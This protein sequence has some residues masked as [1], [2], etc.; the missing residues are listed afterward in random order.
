MSI[1][2]RNPTKGFI[3]QSD[4]GSQYAPDNYRK[5]FKTYG[6]KASMSKEGDCWHN[7]IAESF[8]HI[9]KIALTH[10]C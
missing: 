2:T 10:H 5:I 4:G 9:L 6:A 8:F 1:W 7:V 3:F